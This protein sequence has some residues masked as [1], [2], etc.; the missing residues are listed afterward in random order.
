MLF[1]YIN[2]HECTSNIILV[3]L[4]GLLYT[5]TYCFETG[6]VDASIKLVS[7]KDPF[8]SFTVTDIHLKEWYFFHS[9]NLSNT[10]QA[11]RITIA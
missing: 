5:F 11:F 7:R 9:Y 6:K 3:I 1:H 10:T 2:K 4:P 8:K